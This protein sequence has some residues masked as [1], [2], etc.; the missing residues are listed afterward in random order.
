[1]L[2]LNFNFK[3]ENVVLTGVSGGADSVALLHLL[4]NQA[5]K[6]GFNLI[7]IHVNHHLRGKNSQKDAEFVQKI[8]KSWQIQCVIYDVDCKK[9]KN[10]QKLG[11]EET[12]RNLRYDCF[13]QAFK[14][15]NAD[16]LFLA[17]HLNDNVETIL[18]NLIR[19]TGAMGAIGGG[20]DT[21]V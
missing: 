5:E 13:Y 3:K 16:Y 10:E 20:G 7:C 12:A 2:K 6:I 14:K 21:R 9:G 1:M 4:K 17:H 18:L 11:L 8:C 19:G 15:F